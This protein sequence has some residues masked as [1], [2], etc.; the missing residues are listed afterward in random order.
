L[1][2]PALS[3]NMSDVYDQSV[4]SGGVWDRNAVVSSF[5]ALD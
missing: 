4:V 2:H 3:V 1:H 5:A